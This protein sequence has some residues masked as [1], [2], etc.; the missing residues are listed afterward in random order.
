M[1]A[2]L[3]LR[4]RLVAGLALAGA[5][6]GALA[7]A[8]ITPLGKLVAG[9]PPATAT[10]YLWNMAVFGAMAALVSPF[11]TWTAHRRVP[12][13][14]TLVEPLAGAVA[15]AGVA[16]LLGSGIAFLLLAPAGLVAAMLRL[17]RKYR[18]P[19]APPRLHA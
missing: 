1:N 4:L 12:I 5:V 17:G 13:W 19:A 3:A 14:R 8:A 15:G 10:N 18:D 6:A 16:V 11:V 7:G 2:S 9:A